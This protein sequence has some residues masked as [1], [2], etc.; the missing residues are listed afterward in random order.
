MLQDPRFADSESRKANCPELVAIFDEV[1]RSRDRDEWIEILLDHG[2]MFC[3]VQTLEEVSSD[4]Q[5]LI[6]RYL[7][8]FEHPLL[9]NILVPG[10][11]VHFSACRAG[12][13]SPSP[14]LGENTDLILR[15]LG[16]TEQQ[17][18]EMKREGVTR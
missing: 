2:L 11:P 3:P 5:A 10:Y 15:E 17:I 13:R 9:G 1:F 6:N 12:I 18:Q 14:A 4:P 7:I 16:Y 8:P